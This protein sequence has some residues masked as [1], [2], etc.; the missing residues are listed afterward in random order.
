MRCRRVNKYLLAFYNS[1][2][3]KTDTEKVKLHLEKCPRCRKEYS[4]LAY[5]INAM[6]N[7][8][9]VELSSDFTDRLD[10]K[11]MALE[12]EL[13][14]KRGIGCSL[15][16]LW[17]YVLLSPER[18]LPKA[19]FSILILLFVGLAEISLN[20]ADLEWNIAKLPVMERSILREI[21]LNYGFF[22]IGMENR[23]GNIALKMCLG[24]YM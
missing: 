8:Q 18:F 15:R 1:E 20:F 23:D 21:N 9:D 5:T 4:A 22:E 12:N 16:N 17:E 14:K 24:S 19:A 3:N 13:D 11:I 10:K 2:L 7:L 6:K